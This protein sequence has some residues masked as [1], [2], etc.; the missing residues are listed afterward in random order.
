MKTDRFPAM[1]MVRDVGASVTPLPG[2]TFLPE[3]IE[4]VRNVQTEL[5]IILYQWK[6]EPHQRQSQLQHLSNEVLMSARRGVSVRVLLNKEHQKH[7]LT[8]INGLTMRY[9]REAGCDVKFGPSFPSTHAKLWLFD[10]KVTVL[11]SHNL[12]KKAVFNNDEA[13]VIIKSGI[14]TME[15]LRYFDLLWSRF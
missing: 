1:V 9:L 15:Y 10:R 2:R 13:S 7:H 3:V 6:W 8:S 11:G 14:A 4:L 12:S 5:Q